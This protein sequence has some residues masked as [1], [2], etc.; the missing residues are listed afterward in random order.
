MFKW[1]KNLFSPRIIP[2][3]NI[4][5][6]YKTESPWE[7]EN[8]E[9]WQIKNITKNGL[10]LYCEDVW[11]YGKQDGRTIPPVRGPQ[12]RKTCNIFSFLATHTKIENPEEYKF[13]Y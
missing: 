6:V 2:K 1:I 4:G 8:S 9:Y 3:V 7:I 5:D 10:I 13:L 12:L 11:N